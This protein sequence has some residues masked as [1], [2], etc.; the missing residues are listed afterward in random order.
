MSSSDAS[1]TPNGDKLKTVFKGLKPK[2]ANAEERAA[3]LLASL[4]DA[5]LA[6][7]LDPQGGKEDLK[8]FAKAFG[9]AALERRLSAAGPEALTE[10]VG[11]LEPKRRRFPKLTGELV[12]IVLKKLGTVK[13][14]KE[15]L[16]P[17]RVPSRDAIFAYPDETALR[18]ALDE[19]SPELLKRIRLEHG[20]MYSALPPPKDKKGEIEHIV[21][22]VFRRVQ[23]SIL[24]QM[25]FSPRARSSE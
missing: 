21:A 13:E 18:A 1:A 16:A 15:A 10:L 5:S 9:R 8:S 25:D 2:G 24:D 20:L 22:S 19:Y 14:P 6:L 3:R 23:G 17:D 7:I 11:R 12:D 4:E